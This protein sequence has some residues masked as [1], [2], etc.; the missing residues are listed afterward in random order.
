MSFVSKIKNGRLFIKCLGYSLFRQ[1]P[2]KTPPDIR[3]VIVAPLAQLGDMVCTTPL[4]RALKKNKPSWHLS[5][6][7]K[8]NYKELLANNVDVDEYVNSGDPDHVIKILRNKTYDVGLLTMP[9][10]GGLAILY[11]AGVKMIIAP[12][13]TGGFSPQQ[14]LLYRL[15]HRLVVS[16]EYQYDRYVPRELLKLL[17]PLGILSHTTKKYLG[18][19]SEASQWADQLI[20]EKV[21]PEKLIIGL[22]VSSGNKIKNWGSEKFARLS[23]YLYKKYEANIVLISSRVDKEEVSGFFKELDSDVPVLSVSDITLDQLK[24]LIAKFSMFVGVDTGPIYIAEAFNIPTVDIIGPVSEKE[25]PPVG[26]L[27]RI[28]YLKNRKSAPVHIFNARIFDNEEAR[29]QSQEIS[30]EMVAS[31]ID[32]LIP[33]LI[34]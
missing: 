18:Y 11:L 33:M 24:A 34:K 7:G 1:S 17:E 27:N 22:S 12:K 19:S 31:E 4:F 23:E 29:R 10:F 20:Q 25:Q 30:F 15:L 3:S 5:V 28:V 13:V 6:L 21:K 9:S 2:K 14:T 16:V 26:P 8:P 32:S